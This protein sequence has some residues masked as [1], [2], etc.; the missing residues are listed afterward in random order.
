MA[1]ADAMWLHIQSHLD[2]SFTPHESQGGGELS[3]TVAL[4][5]SNLGSSAGSRGQEVPG[6]CERQRAAAAAARVRG[7]ER[8]SLL[9]ASEPRAP[10][11]PVSPAAHQRRISGKE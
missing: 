6:V 1:G 11:G 10:L 9:T 8:R 2:S 4:S 7:R 3:V 5:Q